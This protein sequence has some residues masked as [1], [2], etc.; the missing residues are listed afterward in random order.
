VVLNL[1]NQKSWH[2]KHLDIKR[3]FKNVNLGEEVFMELS[4]RLHHERGASK[5]CKLLEVIYRLK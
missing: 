3:T 1:A 5:V 4:K 2:I